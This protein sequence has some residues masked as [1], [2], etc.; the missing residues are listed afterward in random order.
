MGHS[1]EQESG[2]PIPATSC[3]T[4]AD[5]TRIIPDAAMVQLHSAWILPY[6]AVPCH[7]VSN[8]AGIVQIC[9]SVSDMAV[10]YLCISVF[11]GYRSIV[12]FFARLWPELACLCR[13]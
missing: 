10:L 5:S 9:H 3:R 11:A 7:F 8:I 12:V 6:F 2:S 1:S 4:L 13:I